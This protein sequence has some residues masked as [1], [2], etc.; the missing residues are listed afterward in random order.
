MDNL[1][2]FASILF[3]NKVDFQN[4][5]KIVILGRDETTLLTDKIDIDKHN[6][7]WKTCIMM[8]YEQY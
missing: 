6:L 8:H 7:R 2:N 1:C 4:Q 5:F 3:R